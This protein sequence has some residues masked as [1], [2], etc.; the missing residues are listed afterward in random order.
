VTTA[1]NYLHRSDAYSV[2]LTVYKTQPAYKVVFSSG[3][4]VYVSLGGEVLE[5]VPAF[6]ELANN[7]NDHSD[8]EGWNAGGD[9]DGDEHEEEH[10]EEEEHEHESETEAEDGP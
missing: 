8:D 6:V 3:D 9:D 7:R 1:S 5:F 10:E 4:V 2:Q